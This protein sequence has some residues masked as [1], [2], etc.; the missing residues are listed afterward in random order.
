MWGKGKVGK[1][2]VRTQCWRRAAAGAS[3][4]RIRRPNLTPSAFR[5]APLPI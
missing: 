3:I 2:Q 5:G 4:V 1:Q